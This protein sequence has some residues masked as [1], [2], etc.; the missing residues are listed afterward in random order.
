MGGKVAYSLAASE[1]DDT[2]A[3]KDEFVVAV[4]QLEYAVNY[5]LKNAF[6]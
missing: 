6:S 4:Q 2:T 5:L 3:A 1:E